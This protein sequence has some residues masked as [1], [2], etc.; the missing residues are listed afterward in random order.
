MLM[1]RIRVVLEACRA[2]PPLLPVT[3]RLLYALIAEAYE[4][5]EPTAR[6]WGLV[7]TAVE[8]LRIH[9]ARGDR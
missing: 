9:L 3:G 1:F 4:A 5:G 2:I 6:S 7:L 8:Q